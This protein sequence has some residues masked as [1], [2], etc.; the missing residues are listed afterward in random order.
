M[1]V[2]AERCEHVKLDKHPGVEFSNDHL[3]MKSLELNSVKNMR[4]IPANLPKNL[5]KIY[6]TGEPASSSAPHLP[7]ALATACYRTE[8]DV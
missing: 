4:K 6:F 5:E 3:G 1:C 7:G 8:A 2:C